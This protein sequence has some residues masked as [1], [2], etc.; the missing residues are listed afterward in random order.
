LDALRIWDTHDHPAT[1]PRFFQALEEIVTGERGY[2]PAGMSAAGVDRKRSASGQAVGE[3][4]AHTACRLNDARGDFQQPQ[5][6]GVELGPLQI[7]RGEVCVA[8]SEC[9]PT[10]VGMQDEPNLIGERRMAG[11]LVGSELGFVRFEE[12]F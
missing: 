7:A 11:G 10:C 3:D 1:W 4:Q 8:D 5:P 12:A 2:G 6:Q 9:R